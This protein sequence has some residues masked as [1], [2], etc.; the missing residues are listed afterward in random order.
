MSFEAAL[1]MVK[2]EEPKRPMDNGKRRPMSSEL[3]PQIK[4]PVAN[5]KTNRLVPSAATTLLTPNSW[6]TCFSPPAKMALLKD[7]TNVPKHAVVAM[8]SLN[9]LLEI[10]MLHCV[11]SQTFFQCSIA[12]DSQGR[13]VLQS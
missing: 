1:P 6:L 7:A 5:P 3:G 10:V 12:V 9:I 11:R 13:V 8:H 4:G 2:I